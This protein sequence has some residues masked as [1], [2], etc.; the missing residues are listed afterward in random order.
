MTPLLA[1]DRTAIVA[2]DA[3]GREHDRDAVLRRLAPIIAAVTG[4]TE[5]IVACEDRFHF[6]HAALGVWSAGAAIALP[7]NLQPATVEALAGTRGAAVLHDGGHALGID[8][9][10]LAPAAVAPGHAWDPARHFACISTSGTTGA[11]K[12]IRKTAGQLV[13]E[14]CELARTFDLAGA[15]V[16]CTVPPHHIYGLLFG[17]LVPL[18][19]DATIIATAALHAEAVAAAIDRFAVDVLVSTPA[20]LRAMGVLDEGKLGCLRRVFSSGAPLP[21]D[22]AAMLRDRLGVTATEVF[23]SSET[24]GIA[25]RMAARIDTPWTPLA[26]VDV[27]ADTDGRMML[28]SPWLDPDQSQPCVTEDRIALVAGGFVHLGRSDDVIKIGGRRI[29]LGDV[30]AKLLAVPG[31]TDATAIA[32]PATDGRGQSIA[33]FVAGAITP[34][35]VRTE[36]ARWFDASVVPRRIVCLPTLPREPTG[37][38]ARAALLG[39]LGDDKSEAQPRIVRVDASHAVLEVEID[40]TLSPF[41]GHFPGNPIL[42]GAAVLDLVSRAATIAWPDLGA[43]ISIP[44]A[45]F[46]APVKPGNAL[47]IGLHRRANEITFT[48]DRAASDAMAAVSCAVGTMELSSRPSGPGGFPPPSGPEGA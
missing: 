6:L 1:P 27:A 17:V 36:L 8:V 22:T 39:Y 29:A 25:T 30:T 24:G 28:R 12:I 13:D 16:L 46:T 19:A 26:G 48:V 21:A 11:P 44:R 15:R 5:V 42:P 3:D 10:S 32:V 41:A 47:R 45:K 40:P 9:R 7:T 23:G 2:I 38:L 43:P 35:A 20:Q 34:D 14:A 4:H 33:A 37:K 31:V 18:V